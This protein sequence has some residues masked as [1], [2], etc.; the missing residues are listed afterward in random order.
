MDTLT[1]QRL[2]DAL[3]RVYRSVEA[4]P[5]AVERGKQRMLRAVRERLERGDVCYTKDEGRGDETKN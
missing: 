1:E 3:R 4:D 2:I 5:A